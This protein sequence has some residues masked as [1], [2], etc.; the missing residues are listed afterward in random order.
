MSKAPSLNDFVRVYDHQLDAALCGQLL[1]AFWQLSG[2]QTANGKG[3]RSGLEDSA[4]TEL[5]LNRHLDA[6]IITLLDRSVDAAL[7]RYNRD[8]GLSLPVPNSPKRADYILKRYR[9]E[10]QERFQLHFDSL[11]EVSNRYLVFLW[12]LNEVPEGGE[13]VFPDLTLAVTPQAGR[14][15]VFPPYWLFCHA[16]EPPIGGEKY[17]LSTYL[18]F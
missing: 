4:W 2:F 13:T 15:L 6:D 12:Y 8:L 7:I 5:N 14:L 17:I 16:G 9:P 3:F 18:L 10:A 11:Y 1:Q